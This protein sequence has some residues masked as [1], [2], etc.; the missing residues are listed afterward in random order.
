ME[1]PTLFFNAPSFLFVY[2][3]SIRKLIFSRLLCLDPRL[4]GGGRL[5]KST[6]FWATPELGINCWCTEPVPQN[7]GSFGS[8]DHYLQG[9]SQHWL[10]TFSPR[11]SHLMKTVPS[12]LG[13]LWLERCVFT[14]VAFADPKGTKAGTRQWQAYTTSVPDPPTK[15]PLNFCHWHCTGSE[16]LSPFWNFGSVRACCT[17]HWTHLFRACPFFCWRNGHCM[18]TVWRGVT[19]ES[20]TCLPGTYF[21]R[22]L[23]TQ[24]GTIQFPKVYSAT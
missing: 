14:V 2:Q 13:L 23:H 8:K 15:L 4:L 6:F 10:W 22:L 5:D 21:Q 17:C 9:S 1:E 19:E 16:G 3:R 11:A 7:L 18:L 12:M 20:D 24:F